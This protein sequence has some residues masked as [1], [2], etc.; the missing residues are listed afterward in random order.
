MLQTVS[1]RSPRRSRVSAP[2]GP[3][4]V[5][6]ASADS[7]DCGR[8]LRGR[9]SRR[10][11]ASPLISSAAAQRFPHGKEPVRR[12]AIFER[13][14]NRDRFAQHGDRPVVVFLRH[15]DFRAQDIFGNFQNV[16]GFVVDRRIWKITSAGVAAS[17][18]R[19]NFVLRLGFR[20]LCP[21][22]PAPARARN[23]RTRL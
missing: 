19:D 14:L 23:A 22:R 7:A 4:A 10:P 17:C 6:T 2:A 15:R 1:A 12:F 11:C 3:G 13:V 16:F 5:P 18:V 9:L 21:C 8:D 20:S